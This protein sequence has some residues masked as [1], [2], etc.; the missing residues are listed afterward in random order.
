MSNNL[1]INRYFK[2][3]KLDLETKKIEV[4]SNTD[5]VISGLGFIKFT[6]REVIEISVVKGTKAYIR[7][8][9]I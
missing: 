4:F 2:D 7:K 8:S 5:L 1:K 3:K 9:F 6:K